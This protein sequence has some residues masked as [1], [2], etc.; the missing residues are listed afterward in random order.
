M[1]IEHLATIQLLYMAERLYRLIFGS[2]IVT[3]K[4]MN[5]Q[6]SMTQETL[7]S[8]YDA[9]KIAYPNVY[10]AYSFESWLN[11]LKT[12]NLITTSDDVNYTITPDSGSTQRLSGQWD[13]TARTALRVGSARWPIS[14]RRERTIGSAQAMSGKYPTAREEVFEL[15]GPLTK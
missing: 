10:N 8:V 5:L 1:L 3:L 9:T 7:R 13:E 12:N 4:H 11:F 15:S 2:Q 14:E 6:G